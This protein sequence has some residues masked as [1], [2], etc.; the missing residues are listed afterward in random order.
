VPEGSVL[1][2]VM[3]SYDLYWYGRKKFVY[4]EVDLWVVGE[5]TAEFDVVYY[6]SF[7]SLRLLVLTWHVIYHTQLRHD[8][9]NQDR[10]HH[11]G[12]YLDCP[13]TPI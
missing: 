4:I 8:L 3:S 2:A 13:Y 9:N 1:D 12:P 7:V 11:D 10:G 6:T 5:F